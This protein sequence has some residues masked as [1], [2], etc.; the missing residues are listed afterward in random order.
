MIARYGTIWCQCTSS[1]VIG[2]FH[3]DHN[4]P[5]LIPPPPTPQKKCIP[6][7]SDFSWVLQTSQEKSKAMH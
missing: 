2:Y 7:V 4:A 3:R 6:F 1:N 5:C